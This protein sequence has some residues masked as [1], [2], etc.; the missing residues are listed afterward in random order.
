[1]S[2]CLVHMCHQRAAFYAGQ[3]FIMTG[4]LV[5]MQIIRAPT[6]PFVRTVEHVIFIWRLM[7]LRMCL[8]IA[9]STQLVSTANTVSNLLNTLCRWLIIN[10]ALCS[11]IFNVFY[12]M[13]Q[14]AI[15][16]RGSSQL[17][18]GLTPC[19]FALDDC[20]CM[21]WALTPVRLSTLLWNQ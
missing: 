15:V 12:L 10:S 16:V 17:S 18:A 13:C 14:F 19:A 11:V 21:D 6:E 9:L 4:A 5:C 2:S 7:S 20:T 8:V 1:M 3:L